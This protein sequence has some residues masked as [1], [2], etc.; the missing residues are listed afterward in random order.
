MDYVPGYRGDNEFLT[1]NHTK[2]SQQYVVIRDNKVN[3]ELNDDKRSLNIFG[4]CILEKRVTMG[5]IML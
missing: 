4:L 1:S 5:L 3:F 2:F